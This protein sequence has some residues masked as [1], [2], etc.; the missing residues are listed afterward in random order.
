MNE[1]LVSRR[2]SLNEYQAVPGAV[3]VFIDGGCVMFYDEYDELLLA[4][5]AGVWAEITQE[6]LLPSGDYSE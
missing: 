6:K 1:Y 4:I 5:A 3:R 2:H